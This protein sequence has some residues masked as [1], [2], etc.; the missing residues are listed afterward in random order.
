VTGT[1]F[2]DDTHIWDSRKDG[3][4]YP[5]RFPIQIKCALAPDDF[6][7]VEPMV[8]LLEYPKRWP[9]ENWTLAFQGN[10]HKLNDHD[11]DLL[12]SAIESTAR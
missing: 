3:E 11:H 2:E 5:F 10:V 7:E 1:Y 12:V 9:R 4:E 6:V 8:D